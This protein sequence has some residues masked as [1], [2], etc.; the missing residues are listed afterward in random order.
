MCSLNT[1]TGRFHTIRPGIH[2]KRKE[3][4]LNSLSWSWRIFFGIDCRNSPNWS[5]N[6]LKTN[7]FESNNITY[8]SPVNSPRFQQLVLYEC[9]VLFTEETRNKSKEVVCNGHPYYLI[10][11]LQRSTR[12]TNSFCVVLP[13]FTKFLPYHTGLVGLYTRFSGVNRGYNE[14]SKFTFINLT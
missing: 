9:A 1:N 3:F 4:I 6:A 8:I 14:G 2:T 5:V 10:R 13:S 7:G 12:H 11:H